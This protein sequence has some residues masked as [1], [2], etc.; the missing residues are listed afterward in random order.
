MNDNLKALLERLLEH[1]IDF[2]LAGGLA[3][4]VHGSPLLTQDLDICISIN[5]KEIS[6][7]RQALR[8]LSP[9]HR[10]NPGFKPSFLDYPETLD[11]VKNIYLETDLGILDIL[12]ELSPIGDFETV[13]KR[14]IPI[15]LYGHTCN[16]V[17]IEDLIQ[18]KETMTRPK[19]KEAAA[20]LKEILKKLKT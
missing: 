14:S 13:K 9:R 16:V 6:K 18:I 15:S 17:S 19:D 7:L 10:M 20:Y 12:S 8:D 4:A 2:V 5:K 3:C 11:G 1:E